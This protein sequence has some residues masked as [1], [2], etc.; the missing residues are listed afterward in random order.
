MGNGKKKF[1]TQF[2]FDEDD[3]LDTFR[4]ESDNEDKSK[5]L[6]LEIIINDRNDAIKVILKN[7]KINS[8][9]IFKDRYKSKNERSIIELR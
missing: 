8:E 1:T 6:V 7:T 2:H 5:L 4:K 9:V 3:V